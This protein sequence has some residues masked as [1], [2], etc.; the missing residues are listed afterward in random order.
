[1]LRLQSDLECT[2]PCSTRRCSRKR[3]CLTGRCSRC[4][5]HIRLKPLVNECPQIVILQ[6]IP[7]GRVCAYGS[8]TFVLILN[9]SH[10]CAKLVCQHPLQICFLGIHLSFAL[11]RRP[12][13]VT[14]ATFT[15][16]LSSLRL[17]FPFSGIPLVVV[18]EEKNTYN[19]LPILF[20]RG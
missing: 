15:C 6:E 12:L 17:A 20:P 9:E 3:R 18:K 1:M 14:A 4:T 11:L 5:G 8:P 16:V 19:L 7:S 10:S 2:R 13:L